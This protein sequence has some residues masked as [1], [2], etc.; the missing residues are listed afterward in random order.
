MAIRVSRSARFAVLGGALALLLGAPAGAEPA[1]APGKPPTASAPS[2]AAPDTPRM[3]ELSG[4]LRTHDPVVIRE[5]K[6]F[7]LFST[8]GGWR[9][10]GIIPIRSSPDLR[11]WKR[12][13]SVFTRLPEWAPKEIPGTRGAWAPDI[14]YFNGRFHLYYSVS[15]F[16]KNTSAIGLVTNTTLDPESPDYKLPFRF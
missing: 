3:L 14:A 5:G 13:G 15:T 10:R 6:T 11:T 12:S 7:Y 8:G 16:G 9:R 1:A 2:R 4:D